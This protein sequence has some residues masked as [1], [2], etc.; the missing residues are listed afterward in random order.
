MRKLIQAGFP[1]MEYVWID[2]PMK[3]TKAGEAIDVKPV[4]RVNE[5]IAREILRAGVPLR[6]VEVLFLRRTLGLSLD[7]FGDL[8]GLSGP[9]VLKWE[10]ARLE[11]QVGI[12]RDVGIEDRLI[13]RLDGRVDCR[14]A[15]R[16]VEGRQVDVIGDGQRASVGSERIADEGRAQQRQR[17]R[18][19]H[20]A[21]HRTA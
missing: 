20:E 18:P 4:S 19:A 11:R 5:A 17:G 7:K 13:E 16:R 21:K 15:D 14:T 8:L 2:V 1:G 3:T 12:L 9:G 6:G 10:Q